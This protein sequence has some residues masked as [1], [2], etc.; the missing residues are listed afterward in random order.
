MSREELVALVAA[1]AEEI[2]MLRADNED[3]RVRLARLERLVSRNSAN[4]SMPPS[5]DG[6]PGKT[7]PD[8]SSKKPGGGEGRKRGK[9]PGAPGANL[10][11]RE[12]PDGRVDRFPEGRCECGAELGGAAD[13]GVSDRYQ[14]TEIPLVSATTTQY[15]QH[16]V[17]CG[18]GKVHTAARP[19]GAGAGRVGYGPNLRAWCVYL[20]VVH[21]IPVHRCVALVESLTGAAPSV[22]FVHGTLQRAAAALEQAD[23]RIRTLIT[24]AYAVCC[25]ETPIRVGPRTPRR[26]RK[27]A[28]KYLLVACTELYTWYMLGDRDLATF[29]AFILAD[30]TGV[31]VHDRYFLYDHHEVGDLTHQLCCSHILRDLEDAAQTYPD[32]HWPTQ[33]QDAL[34]ELIH[35]A[36]LA[37]ESGHQAIPAHV[38]DRLISLFRHGVRVGLSQVRRVPGPKSR[39]KQ[40]IG[41]VL[42]EVLGDR[43]DDVLRFVGD[44]RVPPTSN[45]AERDVRPAKTQQ[46]ISG[47]LTSEARTRDR[48]RIRGV[49]STAAK[50]GLDQLT[51]I[52]D[53]LTGRPWIPPLP[54]PT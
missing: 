35:Y 44:L 32:A 24:L 10:A 13:L 21:A 53:A 39:T 17:R 16:T 38:T 47:R 6:E 42:L 52:R 23:K 4:S 22:G 43:E 19:D 34:R 25:D 46:N 12:D 30:L 31:V 5:K 27:K 41:R 26:G 48:Y 36:N 40:P 8:E 1:Q 11:W 7:A 49:I 51:V 20:M 29:K 9:Q 37:R 33:I 45:Q 2:M 3:L 14:Q 18:C 15:E 28:E 50:H 54:A